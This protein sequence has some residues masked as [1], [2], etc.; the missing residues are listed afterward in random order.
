MIGVGLKDL[1]ERSVENPFFRELERGVLDGRRDFVTGGDQIVSEYIDPRVSG[2]V[3]GTFILARAL[4]SA[5]RCPEEE[6][7]LP[8][9]LIVGRAGCPMDYRVLELGDWPKLATL[10]GY[11]GSSSVLPSGSR[12]RRFVMEGGNSVF[13]SVKSNNQRNALRNEE[14]RTDGNTLWQVTLRLGMAEN[15]GVIGEALRKT[16]LLEEGKGAECAV[17][18]L[19]STQIDRQREEIGGVENAWR[20]SLVP[21]L[22]GSHIT[23]ILARMMTEDARPEKW[24]DCAFRDELRAELA[25]AKGAEPTLREFL[26]ALANASQLRRIYPVWLT[27]FFPEVETIFWCNGDPLWD[28]S[29]PTERFMVLS[30]METEK[31]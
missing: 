14:F 6:P 11:D 24:A 28:K 26:N 3:D 18:L 2:W 29:S 30:T 7:H 4:A 8:V 23:P 22:D 1:Q 16:G 27:R 17:I 31:G 20:P 9:V 5:W 15:D 21:H 19:I 12:I 25:S 13:E 10:A